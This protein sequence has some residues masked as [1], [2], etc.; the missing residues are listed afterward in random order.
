MGARGILAR[1]GKV[2]LIPLLSLPT[3]ASPFLFAPTRPLPPALS[4]LPFLLCCEATNSFK[5]PIGSVEAM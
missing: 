1:G 5:R 2:Y 3:T 4:T